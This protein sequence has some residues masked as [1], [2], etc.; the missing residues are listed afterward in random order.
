[1]SVGVQTSG[2]RTVQELL[3]E[4]E[5]FLCSAFT[6]S[7]SFTKPKIFSDYKC[8][9]I[10]HCFGVS[11]LSYKIARFTNENLHLIGEPGEVIGFPVEPQAAPH[12]CPLADTPNYIPPPAHRGC[13]ELWRTFPGFQG[14]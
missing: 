7:S 4:G 9:C 2:E 11:E 6:A 10:H 13:R 1:M 12:R 8:V 3:A 5:R 14:L